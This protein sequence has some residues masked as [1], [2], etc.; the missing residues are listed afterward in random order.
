MQAVDIHWI[1]TIKLTFF[2]QISVSQ[3][4]LK[5]NQRRSGDCRILLERGSVRLKTGTQ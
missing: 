5:T 1:A 3:Q 2:L 4:I